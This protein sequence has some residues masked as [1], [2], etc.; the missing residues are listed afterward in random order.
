M[1]EKRHPDEKPWQPTIEKMPSFNPFA[2]DQ[3]PSD[4][5]EPA[6]DFDELEEDLSEDIKPRAPK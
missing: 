5:S 1:S 3:N 6:P 2:N 4:D